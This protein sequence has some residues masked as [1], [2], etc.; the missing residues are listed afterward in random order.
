MQMILPVSCVAVS[1]VKMMHLEGKGDC[2]NA[3]G[4]SGAVTRFQTDTTEE[5][6]IGGLIEKRALV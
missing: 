5:Y 2:A 4:A 1:Q 3:M 6:E